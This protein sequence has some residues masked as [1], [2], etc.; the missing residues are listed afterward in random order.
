MKEL[1]DHI[2]KFMEEI[3]KFTSLTGSERK[4][5]VLL[6]MK[7]RLGD[8]YYNQMYDVIDTV[9]ETVVR[10]SKDRK[11]RINIKKKVGK[12]SKLLGCTKQ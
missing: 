10:V 6:R 9:I 12:L 11:L 3:E 2:K 7:D 4:E 8:E 1:Y 5:Y